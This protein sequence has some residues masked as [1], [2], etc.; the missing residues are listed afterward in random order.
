MLHRELNTN[1]M[2]PHMLLATALWDTVPYVIDGT[3]RALVTN[4][5]YLAAILAPGTL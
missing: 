5:C 2:Q 3:Y 4:T 1:E